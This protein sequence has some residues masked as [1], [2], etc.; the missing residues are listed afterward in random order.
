MRR[1]ANLFSVLNVLKQTDEKVIRFT[2][3]FKKS[4]IYRDINIKLRVDTV[5]SPTPLLYFCRR[6]EIQ[7]YVLLNSSR[8]THEPS[9]RDF[10][11]R[12]S[13]FG[14]I[15]VRDRNSPVTRS[16]GHTFLNTM[17]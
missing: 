6:E 15:Q 13:F 14:R 17:L 12:R 1:K 10:V 7:V 16:P 3:M 8:L 5:L 11:V 4:G 9:I 2:R